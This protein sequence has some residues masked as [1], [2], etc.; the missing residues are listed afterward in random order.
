MDYS[1][2]MKKSPTNFRRKKAK[3]ANVGS[4][5]NTIVSTL[6]LDKRLKERALINLWPIVVG[7]KFALNTRPLFVDY[8]NNLVVAVRNASVAQELSFVKREIVQQMKRIGLGTGLQIQGVRFSLKHFHE[9]DEEGTSNYLTNER[10]TNPSVEGGTQAGKSV[11][12]DNLNMAEV[13][14]TEEELLELKQMI[15]NIEQKLCVLG[16]VTPEKVHDL[17]RRIETLVEKEMRFKKWHQLQ[18]FPCCSNCNFPVALLHASRRLCSYCYL[19][20]NYSKD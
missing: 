15:A 14:L 16:E 4:V 7:D 3:F 20:S 19:K 8:E 2:E 17:S 13:K 5:L 12:V 11:A 9:P 18:G 6:G 10:K 1:K